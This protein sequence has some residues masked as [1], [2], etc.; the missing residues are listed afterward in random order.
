[1][2]MMS[3]RDVIWGLS[4]GVPLAAVLADP[5]LAAA[6]AG[7]LET[8]AIKTE[9]GR[10]VSGALG[11]PARTPAPA[12]LLIH[13]WWGLNDQIKS[14]A[15]EFAA[16]GYL[17]LACDLYGGKSADTSDG[18][19]A[20]MG[21]V[22]GKKA[23]ETVAAWG[24]W[25]KVHKQGAG[26]L[27]TVGWCFGGG[28]SLNASI[29]TPV[30]ATVVYYGRVAKKAR[31][32]S[33]LKGPVLGHYATR[34][35]WINQQIPRYRVSRP[36]WTRPGRST[37]AIGTKPTTRL[38]TRPAPATTSPTQTWPGNAPW[39]ST[40]CTCRGLTGG[41]FRARRPRRRRS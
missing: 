39:R 23:T 3:R 12:L 40:S 31:E 29:A 33:K 36:R 37:R 16:L 30:D 19:R 6:A 28:W 18:A 14:V 24:E 25:L 8:V 2:T 21:A 27:G 11:V 38:P 13:E 32:L 10:T 34:D 41:G 5:I 35:N 4:A 1:M 15:A 22:D 26:K 7:T 20:L 9:G 17:A